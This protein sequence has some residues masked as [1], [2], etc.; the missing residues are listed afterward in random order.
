M[1]K[2]I[3]ITAVLA[4]TVLSTILILTRSGSTNENQYQFVEVTRGD[5]ENVISCT[6][7][8]SAVGTVEIGTQVSGTIDK[9][10]VDFNDVV[11][12]GQILAVLDTAVLKATVRGAEASV[13]RAE[14][15]LEKAASDHERY[16]R[17]FDQGLIS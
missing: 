5:L 10:L 2:K 4:A 12:K 15:D 14:S 7:T 8:L 6:G 1:K 11:S 3:W 16:Q 17:L 9:V 13:M